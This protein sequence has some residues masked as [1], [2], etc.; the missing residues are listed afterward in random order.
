MIDRQ[1]GRYRLTRWLLKRWR[2]VERRSL[3]TG[4]TWGALVHIRC[5]CNAYNAAA[6][7]GT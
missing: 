5:L 4:V 2:A 6:H 3:R 1:I 7:T